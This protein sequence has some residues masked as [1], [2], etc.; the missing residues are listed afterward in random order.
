M[1][2]A[3]LQAFIIWSGWPPRRHQD[4]GFSSRMRKRT[5]DR[6]HM[7]GNALAKHLD[8]LREPISE[9]MPAEY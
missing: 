9:R 8:F 1:L 7:P 3:I 5:T 2:E 4:W 6:Q